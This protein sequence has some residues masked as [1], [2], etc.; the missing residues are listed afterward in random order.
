MDAAGLEPCG[1][2]TG[3]TPLLETGVAECGAVGARNGQIDA[4]LAAVIEAWPRLSEDVRVRIQE[5]IATH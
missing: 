2:S 5:L 4:G 1:F 3:E